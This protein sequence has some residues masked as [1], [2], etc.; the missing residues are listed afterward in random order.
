VE[1]GTRGSS[2][3]SS[4][5]RFSAHGDARNVIGHLHAGD[6]TAD[7]TAD[8]AADHTAG[9]RMQNAGRRTQDAGQTLFDGSH[10]WSTNVVLRGLVA[11]TAATAAGCRSG[12]ATFRLRLH[13]S[14]RVSMRF[15]RG[16]V[17]AVQQS[18]HFFAPLH[19]S[20]TFC[21]LKTLPYSIFLCSRHFVP[22]KR[23]CFCRWICSR[24]FCNLSVQIFKKISNCHQF[25]SFR[26][27]ER[28]KCQ[29]VVISHY[30]N[31]SD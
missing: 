3:P 19:F 28:G 23:F 14:M 31:T 24:K 25:A 27:G 29:T 20:Y 17:C 16:D 21:T 26:H 9:R 18:K 11:A 2:S 7:R 10:R 30:F 12:S 13:P 4:F 22:S 15:H 5:L 6:H 1:G 8:H